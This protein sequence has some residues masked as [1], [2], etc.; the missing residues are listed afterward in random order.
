MW[1]CFEHWQRLPAV[2]RQDI[3]TAGRGTEDRTLVLRTATERAL[4][5][6]EMEAADAPPTEQARR[7][8]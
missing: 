2:I 5:F 6:W 8:G 4:A 3:W 1:A 7:V